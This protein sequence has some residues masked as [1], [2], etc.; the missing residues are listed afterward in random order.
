[1]T[2]RSHRGV[3]TYQCSKKHLSRAAQPIDDLITALVIERLSQDD[4]GELLRDDARPD[5]IALSDEAQALR[6][7][8]DELAGMYADGSLSRRQFELANS[9]LTAQ[10]ERVES[11][12]SYT[13][14]AEVLRDLVGKDPAA[15]WERLSV[16][17]RTAVIRELMVITLLPPGRGAR[18]FDP[19]TVRVEWK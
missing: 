10:L 18:S 12:L 4:A 11:Q 6:A 2:G 14:R 9:R 16:D 1:M 3:R 15:V 5:T 13:S 19:T 8:Q 17:R 7:R